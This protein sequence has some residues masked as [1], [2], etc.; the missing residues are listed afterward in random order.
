M[1]PTFP[2]FIN[3]NDKKEKEKANSETINELVEEIEYDNTKEKEN[4]KY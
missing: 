3:Y 1:L 4:K 2:N